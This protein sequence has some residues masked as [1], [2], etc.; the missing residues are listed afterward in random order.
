MDP[1]KIFKMLFYALI[2]IFL[3]SVIRKEIITYKSWKW[4]F[5]SKTVI[6]FIHLFNYLGPVSNKYFL[7]PPMHLKP[8]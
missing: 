3:N 4:R 8:H 2:Q 6:L 1:R 5:A 7:A